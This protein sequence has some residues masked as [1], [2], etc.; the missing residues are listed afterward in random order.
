M[1]RVFTLMFAIRTGIRRILMIPRD[2][3]VL[4]AHF[5]A[6]VRVLL[7]LVS[8]NVGLLSWPRQRLHPYTRWPEKFRQVT[9]WPDYSRVSATSASGEWTL[10]RL[11]SARHRKVQ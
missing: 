11:I 1:A 7:S 2:F 4:F 9:G 6:T 5:V 10:S 8:K 3:R